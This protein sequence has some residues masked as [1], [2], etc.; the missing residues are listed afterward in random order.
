MTTRRE[1]LLVLSAA[2]LS[3]AVRAQLSGYVYRIGYFG[4]GL[5]PANG[6]A[7]AVLRETL[8]DFGYVEGKN[9]EYFARWSELRPER[10]PAIAREMVDAKLDAVVCIGYPTAYAMKAATPTIPIV[11]LSVG[12]PVAT[13]LVASLARPGGNLTGLSDQSDELSAKRMEILKELR[14]NAS[15][16]AVMWNAT[17]EAMTLRYREIER[18]ATALHIDVQP[19]GV[20]EPGEF[21]GAFA[22][23]SRARPDA[24]LV[25]TDALTNSNQGRVVDFASKN[26][27]PAMYEFGPIVRNGGLISYGPNPDDALR[28][29]AGY[30]N[31]ILKGAKPA[32][33]PVEQPTHFELLLNMKTA[34]TLGVPIPNSVFLRADEVIR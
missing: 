16:I 15:R 17:N 3:P 33:L 31:R 2:L 27:V 19:L 32:Q 9:V 22:A 6:Q 26:D 21:E 29:V 7:P 11:F 25:I 23:M 1:V 4:N 8:R 30:V 28:R 5:A 14:P 34:K 20:R 18:A 12:D 24:L 13:G 10:L